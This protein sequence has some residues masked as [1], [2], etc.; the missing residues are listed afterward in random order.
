[1]EQEDE[2]ITPKTDAPSAEQDTLLLVDKIE[3]ESK[4]KRRV[5]RAW[6]KILQLL[7]RSARI[8]EKLEDV[9]REHNEE[10]NSDLVLH[11]KEARW[12]KRFRE[13]KLAI[14]TGDGSTLDKIKTSSSSSSGG[15]KA[16]TEKGTGGKGALR[17]DQQEEDPFVEMAR[18]TPIERR[19]RQLHFERLRQTDFRKI[20]GVPSE[21]WMSPEA[22]ETLHDLPLLFA[23]PIYDYVISNSLRLFGTFVENELQFLTGLTIPGDVF[24]DVGANMGAYA[25][26][27]CKWLS[28]GGIPEWHPASR[29]RHLDVERERKDWW[30]EK[31]AGKVVDRSG[32]GSDIGGSDT[33]TSTSGKGGLADEKTL[34]AS[35]SGKGTQ[36]G[37]SATSAAETTISPAS[38][39]QLTQDGLAA[40]TKYEPGHVYAFEPFRLLFQKL[41]GNA[42]ING[43]ENLHAFNFGLADGHK[44]LRNIPGPDMRKLNYHQMY[45][46][47][48]LQ[49]ASQDAWRSHHVELRIHLHPLDSLYFREECLPK[50]SW[51]PQTLAQK[52][53]D[54]FFGTQDDGSSSGLES[55]Y[56]TLGSGDAPDTLGSAS[57]SFDLQQFSERT[58]VVECPNKKYLEGEIEEEHPLFSA[59]P[60]EAVPWNDYLRHNRMDLLKVDIEGH[61]EAFFFGA[62]HTLE[63]FKPTVVF[64]NDNPDEK[65]PHILSHVL[66]YTCVKM[67]ATLND[68]MVCVVV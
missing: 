45:V 61:F 20:R 4:R 22:L 23:L 15:S 48:R 3:V 16:T 39:H 55:F 36:K 1:M 56:D 28:L 46:T 7:D 31:E 59:L 62:F 33:T 5:A 24:V 19:K 10:D 50:S 57:P 41:N 26:P 54:G 27:M 25:I 63:Y 66:G 11:T 18:K 68:D 60:R 40:A 21:F 53:R 8:K 49:R 67:P 38:T 52:M 44:V 65:I 13:E 30:G 64:E 43:L 47:E 58:G 29:I 32:G 14:Q 37:S 35:A 17:L 42:A 34:T 6:A 51:G 12:E 9:K 2:R